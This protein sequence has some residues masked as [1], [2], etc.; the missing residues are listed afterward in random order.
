[1]GMWHWDPIR[2]NSPS[3]RVAVLKLLR[4]LAQTSQ[5]KTDL[6]YIYIFLSGNSRRPSLEGLNGVVAFTVIG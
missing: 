2:L 5:S 1:M 3:P 6:I 4:S